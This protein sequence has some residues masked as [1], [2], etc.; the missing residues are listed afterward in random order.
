MHNMLQQHL[1]AKKLSGTSGREISGPEKY[2]LNTQL[3]FRFYMLLGI[4]CKQNPES[5]ML[6]YFTVATSLHR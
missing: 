6:Y 2:Q 1:S 4:V 5:I 3:S